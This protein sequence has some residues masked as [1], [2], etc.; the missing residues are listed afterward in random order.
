[1]SDRVEGLT[2]YRTESENAVKELPTGETVEELYTVFGV[3]QDYGDYPVIDRDGD[4][5]FNVLVHTVA[6]PAFFSVWVKFIRPDD[7]VVQTSKVYSPVE[8]R[9]LANQL[10]TGMVDGIIDK[11]GVETAR[12]TA[13]RIRYAADLAG[14]LS[15]SEM[16]G[17]GVIEAFQ[18]GKITA[19][20]TAHE[21]SRRFEKLLADRDE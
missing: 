21:M 8:A 15:L 2:A 17:D 12:E 6:T 16:A 3:E 11:I 7:D 10:Q 5:T 19:E 18:D 1:M 9:Q 13:G 4:D 14:T 20:E